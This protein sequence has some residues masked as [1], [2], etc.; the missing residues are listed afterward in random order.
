M[1]EELKKQ[2]CEANLL[3]PKY[4]MVTFTWGNVSGIDREQGLMVIKPSGV[5]YDGMKPED[6]VV[7]S[8]ETGERVEGRYKPPATRIRTWRCTRLSRLWGASFTPTAVGPPPSP[9]RGKASRPREPPR[10]ITSTAK[11]PAPGR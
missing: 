1:L 11:S 6:M 10:G 9:K 2:V 5:E 7:V 3:L 4:G 8:L